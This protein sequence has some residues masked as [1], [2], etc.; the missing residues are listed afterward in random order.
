MTQ[1]HVR[2]PENVVRPPDDYSDLEE[3]Y[4]LQHEAV[5]PSPSLSQDVLQHEVVSPEDSPS[6]SLTQEKEAIPDHYFEVN[7]IKGKT[8]AMKGKTRET[9]SLLIGNHIFRK[10]NILKDGTIKFSCN[11]CER[12]KKTVCAF[13]CINKN[14]TSRMAQL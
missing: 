10:K 5:S 11:G 3:S 1:A 6:P 14:G 12:K 7:V 2:F 8:G 4:V 13:A 9:V